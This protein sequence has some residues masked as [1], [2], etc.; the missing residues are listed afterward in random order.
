MTEWNVD[1]NAIKDDKGLISERVKERESVLS[2]VTM[3]IRK[4]IVEKQ[5]ERS[6][7]RE[8]KKRKNQW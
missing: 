1:C 7:I 3:K 6:E 4:M 2:R 8:E 5:V